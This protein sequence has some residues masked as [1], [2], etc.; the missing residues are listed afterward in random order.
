[1]KISPLLRLSVAAQCGLLAAGVAAT[2]SLEP[3]PECSQQTFEVCLNG[4]STPVTN[5]PL[6]RSALD[7]QS[8]TTRRRSSGQPAASVAARGERE[9]WFA[10]GDPRTAPIGL[11]VSYNYVDATSDFA[12]AGATLG[13]ESD[14]HSGLAGADRLFFGDRLLLGLSGGYTTLSADTVHNGGG[15]EH[16]G[17]TLAPY[18]ALLLSDIF[19]IDASGGYAA[20]DY[21]QHRVSP[22]DGTATRSSFDADRWF[23]AGNVN[24][25]VTR[26][27]WLGSLRVGAAH[28]SERQDA[29]AE[30][31][32]AASALGGTLRSV[33]ER[34]IHLTQLVVGGEAAYSGSNVEPYVMVAY[35]N[36]LDREDDTG[37]GGMP[38]AFSVVQPTDDDE[39][40]L[41]LGLRCY[42]QRGVTA[43][44]EY[45]RV[46]GREDFDLDSV[47][48]TLRLA[49]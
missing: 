13:F 45:L 41:G 40:Q 42:T 31:G 37:A 23:I 1:M 16:D 24:A 25:S 28:A 3:S 18:A 49:L 6:M 19:S 20:L 34:E 11:W 36:D 30:S 7:A 2:P 35:H 15:E 46:E 33:R 4:A 29:Y 14:G 43:T 38:G 10:A 5:V 17:Y 44:L 48:A 8:E 47:M 27:S 26:G 32:S 21:D 39:V 9:A 12:S 22:T